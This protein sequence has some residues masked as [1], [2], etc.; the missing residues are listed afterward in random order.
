MSLVVPR[1]SFTRIAAVRSILGG[2]RR[3][4]SVATERT[5][6]GFDVET[7]GNIAV[8]S[9]NRPPV[10]SFDLPYLRGFQALIKDFEGNPAVEG[11]G[12]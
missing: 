8:V 11:L 1:R 9:L 6:N 7:R 5:Y 4:S 10:N 3:L 2:E 12:K